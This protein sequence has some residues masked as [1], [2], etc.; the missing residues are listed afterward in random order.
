MNLVFVSYVS[1]N[2]LQWKDIANQLTDRT[3]V[4]CFKQLKEVER[5]VVCSYD[6]QNTRRIELPCNTCMYLVPYVDGCVREDLASSKTKI[7]IMI[8]ASSG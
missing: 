8:A 7:R 1:P 2:Q 6:N 3:Q 4:K 5:A